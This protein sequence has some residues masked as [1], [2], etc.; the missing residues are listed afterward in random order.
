M[1]QADKPLFVFLY[2]QIARYLSSGL[3]SISLDFSLSLQLAISGCTSCTV[4]LEALDVDNFSYRSIILQNFS[5]SKVFLLCLIRQLDQQEARQLAISD[6]LP[7]FEGFKPVFP[8][9]SFPFFNPK[10]YPP[11]SL[12]TTSQRLD[13]GVAYYTYACSSMYSQATQEDGK[14]ETHLNTCSSSQ[15]IGVGDDL[16]V[17]KG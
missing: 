8:F 9:L 1:E 4:V 15:G 10:T 11:S 3:E 17:S 14:E 2:C 5:F 7:S 13:C 12:P 6:L 16:P